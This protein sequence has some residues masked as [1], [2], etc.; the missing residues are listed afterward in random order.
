MSVALVENELVGG[1]CNYW[2]C[3]PSKA[4]LRPPEALTEASEVEGAKQAVR[5]LLSA[6]SVLS[7]RDKFVDNWDDSNMKAM[8][9]KAGVVV[10]RG[11]GHLDGPKRVVVSS[12]NGG[13]ALVAN[14]AV[15]LSTGTRASIDRKVKGLTEAQPWTNRNATGAKKVPSSLAIMGDGPVACEMAH[16]W[17]SLGTKVTIL[18]R[19]D[20]I[21]SRYEPFVGERL[22]N[23][24]KHRGISVRANVNV[25]EVERPNHKQDHPP[26]N[27]TLDDGTTITAQELLV[28]IGRTPNTDKLG[29][30]TI[31]LK[32][33]DWL[34]AVGDINHRALLTHIGKYQ[35]R[36][37]ASAII[38]RAHGT[39]TSSNSGGSRSGNSYDPWNKWVA[40]ADHAAVPQVIFTDPQIASV[41]FT[42]KAARSLKINVRAVDCEIDTVVGAMLHTDGYT[43]HARIIVDEDRH[44]I[45]GATM[46]GPQVGDLLH[47]T[48]IAIIGE[49]PLERLWHAVPSFPTMSEVWLSLLE[50]YGL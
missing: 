3:V 31:G 37:C 44:V 27:I 18:S 26:L 25:K 15:V 42:E 39:L 41:G 21:L 43:G 16:V 2:A 14:Q 5:G 6:E 23:V 32:P 8:V 47:S 29:L 9:E 17:S 35:A 4:L 28:A 30:E 12:K 48:T 33:G 49:V 40:T 13:I 1:E 11:Q 50:N 20:G 45:V 22:M 7:R 34:Y 36:A 19:N 24:F 38:A 46:I 10:V